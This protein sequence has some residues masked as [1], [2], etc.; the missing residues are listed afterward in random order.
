[1]DLARPIRSVIP[2][3]HGPAL[4]VLARAGRPLTGRDVARLLAG[5]GSQRGVLNAL[6]H[7]VEHGIVLREDHPPAALF[8]LNS[9]HLAADA[10]VDLATMRERLIE[11]LREVIERWQEPAEA[12]A[13]FGSAARAEGGPHS[14]VDLLVIRSEGVEPARWLEQVLAL[15]RLMTRWTGNPLHVLDY[16]VD[17]LEAAVIDDMTLADNLLRDARRVVGPSITLLLAQRA[18]R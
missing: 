17:E 16:T 12:A 3:L 6:N 5:E 10:I 15:Q 11:R 18:E 9:E 8:S 2:T 1:M 7:L 4:D 13:L 14:D